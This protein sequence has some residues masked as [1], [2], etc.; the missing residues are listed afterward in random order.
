LK[1]DNDAD[2]AHRILVVAGPSGV[3]KSTVVRR[4]LALSPRVWL[5]VSYTT[6]RPRS[7]EVDGDQY[8]FVSR[9]EFEQLRD[10][11]GFVE[12]AEFA[13]NL[14][15]T[16]VAPIEAHLAAGTPV[17]LEIDVQGV[18]QI[19]AAIPSVTTVFISP[20]SREELVARLAGRGTEDGTQL[21][22]RLAAAEDELAAAPEFDH[23]IVNGDVDEAAAQLLALFA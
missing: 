12:W 9:D 8:I 17:I 22:A 5:S 11:G 14:Y 15:G 23:V 3:G 20:P 2:L 6:R 13:D 7:G 16:P 21:A 19:R 4:A 1:I 10:A 18:R